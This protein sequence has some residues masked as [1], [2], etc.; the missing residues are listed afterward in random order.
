MVA[1]RVPMVATDSGSN[2]QS[3]GIPGFR[4]TPAGIEC[5]GS[6]RFRFSPGLASR[7]KL[8]GCTIPIPDVDP[9]SVYKEGSDGPRPIRWKDDRNRINKKQKPRLSEKERVVRN[10]L[11]TERGSAS[12]GRALAQ[13]I[14]VANQDVILSSGQELYRNIPSETPRP[15]SIM[16]TSVGQWI[17][18][19]D[20]RTRESFDYFAKY[21]AP[22]MVVLDISNGYRDIILPMAFED[23]LLQQAVAVVAAQHLG[24]RH[25][26]CRAA[27]ESSRSA[28]ISRLRRDSQLGSPD[29]VFN[30]STWATLIV[31][32]VGETVTGSSEYSHLLRTLLTLA[33]NMR[34]V[35]NTELRDFLTKQTDM[36]A[37][38][39]QPL[40]NED[41]GAERLRNPVDPSVWMASR[42]NADSHHHRTLSLVRKVFSK[43]AQIYL[44]RATTNQSSWHVLEELRQL[45]C[46]MSPTE[47]GAHGFVWS[48]FIAA[49]D[50]VDPEHRAF[51]SDYLKGVYSRTMFDNIP[52][53]LD[54]LPA[55]WDLQGSAK[56]VGLPPIQ[57]DRHGNSPGWQGRTKMWPAYVSKG[58]IV[59]YPIGLSEPITKVG[60]HTLAAS[61]DRKSNLYSPCSW[62]VQNSSSGVPVKRTEG[63]AGGACETKKT[64]GREEKSVRACFATR[65]RKGME[66]ALGSTFYQGPMSTM[67]ILSGK[68]TTDYHDGRADI[69]LSQVLHITL[70][71][72]P[73]D[74]DGNHYCHSMGTDRHFTLSAF[75]AILCSF[76]DIVILTRNMR[77]TSQFLST[78]QKLDSLNAKLCL[79]AGKPAYPAATLKV[80]SLTSD[81]TPVDWLVI[82]ILNYPWRSLTKTG[83][84]A[85]ELNSSVRLWADQ[86]SAAGKAQSGLSLRAV[87]TTAGIGTL[88][89]GIES[90]SASQGHMNEQALNQASNVRENLSTFTQPHDVHLPW[91]ILASGCLPDIASNVVWLWSGSGLALGSDLG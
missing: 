76:L 43:G 72:A 59:N 47:P 1:E 53:A 54:A 51:F 31:L 61:A 70:Y 56:V 9:R 66:G 6:G 86:L 36:F 13:S 55:I 39:G 80:S 24:S 57:A 29:L 62:M 45:L 77:G 19:V 33:Q 44:Q 73:H 74:T 20:Y 85:H 5:S 48:C 21:I 22:V 12:G 84:S 68:V 28:I 63:I 3:R 49:A 89:T 16:E 26:S 23:S 52:K 10:G 15:S 50:S 58:G 88:G 34:S 75:S 69:I 7:G 42:V 83:P 67:Q 30:S 18:P 90:V 27:T 46:Q 2:S 82:S 8:K 78:P 17:A 37:F 32:L 11:V 64:Y 38:L 87:E 65:A 40:L 79:F 71:P 41:L 91:Q 25:P 14:S 81:C 4:R 60:H 35:G